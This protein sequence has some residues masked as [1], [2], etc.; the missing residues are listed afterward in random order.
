MELKEVI[1]ERKRILFG[2]A[3]YH[4]IGRAS[5]QRILFGS[6]EKRKITAGSA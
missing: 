2:A 1:A 3:P 4:E 6:P 5:K